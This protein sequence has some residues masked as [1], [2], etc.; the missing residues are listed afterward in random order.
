MESIH[1]IKWRPLTY[2]LFGFACL[3]L[4]FIYLNKPDVATASNEPKP[5]VKKNKTDAPSSLKTYKKL[6]NKFKENN[7]NNKRS[8]RLGKSLI[9]QPLK[10]S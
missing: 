10:V 8:I 7:V 9:M 5:E 4:F 2:F 6:S 3:L 1:K